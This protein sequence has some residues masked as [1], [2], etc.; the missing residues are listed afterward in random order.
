MLDWMMKIEVKNMSSHSPIRAGAYSIKVP[1]SS[2]SQTLQF[3]RRSGG[4]VVEVAKL[5]TLDPVA[6]VPQQIAKVA[7]ST[8]LVEPESGSTTVARAEQKIAQNRSKR[9]GK[10]KR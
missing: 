6:D 1:F 3:I 9:G 2:L 7:T 5:S 4:K 10:N 8:A